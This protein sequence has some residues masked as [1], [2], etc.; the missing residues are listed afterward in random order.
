TDP[1]HRLPDLCL[2][3][4]S[5]GRTAFAAVPY[6]AAREGRPWCP[7]CTTRR[8]HDTAARLV[9]RVLP[10]VPVRQWVLSLPR[11]ARWQLARNPRLATRTLEVALRSI[12]ASLRK[13]ARRMGVRAPR[14][15]AVR[16]IQRFGS[17][18]NL[19]V[20]FH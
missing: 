6:P 4:R 1:F 13:R 9:D 8:M 19:N 11:W 12:F 3:E 16:F 14:A 10:H 18:L 5:A 17:A 2:L 20:H 15:G 7:S